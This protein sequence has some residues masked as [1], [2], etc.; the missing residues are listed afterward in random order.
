MVTAECADE[1]SFFRRHVM[2]R[3]AYRLRPYS[4]CTAG[5][6]L[7]E[8]MVV[9]SILALLMA[10]LLPSLKSARDQAAQVVCAARLQQ[11]GLAFSCYAAENN[12]VLPHCDGLDRGPRQLNDP[13]ISKEDVA[14]WHGWVDMLPP[15]I[16]L[17]CWRDHPRFERPDHT[18]FY[19]CP[20]ARPL[21]ERGVYAYKPQ[22]DGY[23]SYAM[24]SCLELDS[25]AWAPPGGVGYP[26]PSF[27][28]TAR[29]VGAGRVILLFEQL[30][31]PRKG[32]DGQHTYRSAGK[33]CGSYPKAFSAR[34]P[35]YRSGLGGNVLYCD[36]HVEWHRSLW[37]PEWDS[38]LKVPP[39]GDPNWYP[40]PVV[41]K[42]AK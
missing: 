6:T 36:N 39:R 29:I 26:M 38:D 14:D 2:L 31:D 28:D 20:F 4:N 10:I 42:N 12:G 5:F 17:K 34:H 3:K 1:R 32:Y 22:R 15:T 27:L 41:E 21:E 7:V 9:V 11:W 24:N 13:H 19:Q 23:F 33:H 25:N 35:R 40:Y 18:T 8:L 37:K 30:L 16:G